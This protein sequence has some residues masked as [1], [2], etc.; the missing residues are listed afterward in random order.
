MMLKPTLLGRVHVLTLGAL[1]AG[2]CTGD[3]DGVGDDESGTETG[4]DT[5]AT[6]TVSTT[7]GT[8]TMSAST[9]N[10]GTGTMSAS[11][12][13]SETDG[14]TDA[15]DGTTDG[16]T[17]VTDT[18]PTDS[19]T[20]GTTM[21]TT[22]G[23]TMGTTD[24]TTTESAECG[25][26]VVEGGE[27]CD[28][29]NDV[30]GDGCENSCTNTP[31]P[32]CPNQD[33][34]IKCD[35][36]TQDFYK[37]FEVGCSDNPE[38][39]VVISNQSLSSNNPNAWRIAKGFGTYQQMGKLL[40]SPQAGE[41]F[42]MV[43]TGVIAQPNGQGVVTEANNSQVLNADNGNDDSNSLPIPISVNKGSN[44]GQGGTP[45]MNCDGVNDCSDSL[46][47]AWN[48]GTGDP[49]DKLSFTFQAMVPDTVASYSFSFAYFSSEWPTYVNTKYNDLLIAWQVSEAYTG[50]VTF[51]GDAPLTV[52]SLHPYLMSDGYSG[53][54]AQ[55][56]GTGFEQHAGSDWFG[57]NQNVMGGETLTMTFM[58]ADMGDSILATLAI[59]DNFHWNCEA[60]IPVDDPKC[61]G[62]VPD[63]NCCGVV[64][65]Q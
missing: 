63:P 34:A 9:T 35:G 30:N 14:T 33:T 39:T 27:Q 8:G 1:L 49:N 64:E 60:C 3:D 26:G 65:P 29:G 43:S 36:N 15:T 62:E 24:G 57:A 46:F 61:T 53:N 55:L 37:A 21:G 11:S 25:N 31:P 2:G 52:T 10:G 42:L 50:N 51:I 40:Y 41:A 6:S 54:E 20:D 5:N 47:D 7:A 4:T 32:A 56:Q 16:T 17:A 18:D 38:E 13:S 12:S 59:I 22:D 28:D 58:I 23:T 45:F 44:N 48:L 19:T